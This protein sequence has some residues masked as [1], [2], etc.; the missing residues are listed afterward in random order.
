MI[1]KSKKTVI[2]GQV[3]GRPF[4]Y[5]FM[6]DDV[7]SHG[8]L[9]P[10]IEFAKSINFFPRVAELIPDSR[11]ADRIKHSI[12]VLSSVLILAGYLWLSQLQRP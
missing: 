7:T 12:E 3:E 8:G 5:G 11:R 6:G 4:E 1:K 10:I 2:L 9:Q